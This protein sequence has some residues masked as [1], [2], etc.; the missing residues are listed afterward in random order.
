MQQADPLAAAQL[1]RRAGTITLAGMVIHTKFGP[2]AA[3]SSSKPP[4]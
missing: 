1:N 2:S 4:R 3:N